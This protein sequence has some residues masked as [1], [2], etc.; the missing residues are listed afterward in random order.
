MSYTTDILLEVIRLAQETKPFATIRR[1]ALPPDNGI[2]MEIA[3]GA[4]E[5]TF[6]DRRSVLGLSL[7]LNGKH[8]DL[9]AV[10]D[11]LNTIH[12]AL[13]RMKEYPITEAWQ[14]LNI[15]TTSVPHQISREADGQW[16]FGSSLDVKFFERR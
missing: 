2:C 8:R 3:T 15:S 12:H 5:T 6:M 1:G 9:A 14:I 16:L 11:A 7:V 4:P 13:T 10:S